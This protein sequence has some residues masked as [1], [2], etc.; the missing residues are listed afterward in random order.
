MPTIKLYHHGVTAGIPPSKK[1]HET[2]KR[3][4]V[5]GWSASA[6]RNNTRWLRSVNPNFLIQ[7]F[8]VL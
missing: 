2:A 5:N 4:E 7:Q 3:G 6:A 1:S 8:G